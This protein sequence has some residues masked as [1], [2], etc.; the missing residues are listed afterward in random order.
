[1]PTT[2]ARCPLCSGGA[3]VRLWPIAV[4]DKENGGYK[5]LLVCEEHRD[6]P[7]ATTERSV[8]IDVLKQKAK[9]LSQWFKEQISQI[10][11]TCEC[12]CGKTFAPPP[13]GMT[14]K[15]YVAHIVPKRPKGGVPSVATH[16]QN[17]IFL[18]WDCHT[19]Y[20]NGKMNETT[21][22]IAKERYNQF[23]NLIPE[24]EMKNVQAWLKE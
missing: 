19:D 15:M 21:K 9:T 23:K 17:R 14:W 1:M 11:K 7:K 13:E 10:P 24:S 5:E 3:K 12:G 2:I 18:S 8:I 20:D 16:P 4:D 6:D 22:Q